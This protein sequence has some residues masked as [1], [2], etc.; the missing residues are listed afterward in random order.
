MI[1]NFLKTFLLIL[2]FS[3]LIVSNS[4]AKNTFLK[5][6]SIYNGEIVF[7]FNKYLLPD[8]D[9]TYFYKLG[10]SVPGTNLQISCIHFLNEKNASVEGYFEICD[11][12][13]GGKWTPQIAFIISNLV[14]NDRYD[15]CNLKPEYYY[16]KYIS[17]GNTSNCFVF[18]HIDVTKEINYPDDPNTS[19]D[20]FRE[21]LENKNLTLPKIMIG[22]RHLFFAPSIKDKAVEIIHYINPELI[23]APATIESNENLTE[24]HR[25]NIK[26]YPE[27]KKIVDIFLQ[28]RIKFHKNFE[29]LMKAKKH[30]KI[31]FN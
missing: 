11:L 4:L 6:G 13:T 5:N 1:F 16:A 24:Y 2:I 8:G 3:F 27:K 19:F 9:W 22:S 7:K 26:N 10:E 30:H 28:D 23:G 20:F 31:D 14:K 17:I 15:N 18:R 25:G 29:I 21:Y 12:T